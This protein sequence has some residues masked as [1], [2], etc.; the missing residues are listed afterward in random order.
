MQE[1]ALLDPKLIPAV[2]AR[3]RAMGE[4]GR[5]LLLAELHAGEKSVGELVKAT[6]RSQPNVSQQL[7]SLARAGLV[8]GRREGQHVI[9]R[10]ADP[11]LRRICDAVCRSLTNATSRKPTR[12]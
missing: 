8:T 10:I 3:F 7:A 11:Y 1:P 2:A 4:A 6:R 5:L 9:Y 12:A